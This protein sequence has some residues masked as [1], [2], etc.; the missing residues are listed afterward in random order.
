MPNWT[1]PAVDNLSPE[2]WEQ[3][4]Y[5]IS[6]AYIAYMR[7][8]VETMP[9]PGGEMGRIR[10]EILESKRLDEDLELEA[11]R[12]R[13]MVLTAGG[14]DPLPSHRPRPRRRSFVGARKNLKIMEEV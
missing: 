2:E 1:A 9:D 7:R 6:D 11:Q 5:A 12:L 8:K 14:P 13:F 4:Q 10:A 3:Q